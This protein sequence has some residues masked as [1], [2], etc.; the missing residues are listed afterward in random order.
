MLF[1]SMYLPTSLGDDRRLDGGTALQ[2][3]IKTSLQG[4]LHTVVPL[5]SQM[6]GFC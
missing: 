3:F 1:F 4:L 6:P 2:L 5:P